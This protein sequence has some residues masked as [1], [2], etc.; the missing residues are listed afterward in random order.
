MTEL[1]ADPLALLRTRTSTKWARYPADVLPM[2]VAEMD[3]PL[4][5]PI[6]AKLVELV[7]RSDV[8]YDSRR[9][10]LGIAFADFA[11]DAWDWTFDPATL[12]WTVNVMH[13]ITEIVRAVI[14]PGDKVLVNTP[15]YPPFFW[16][17][18][19]AGGTR[20]DVPLVRR[21]PMPGGQPDGWRLDL[22][23]IEAAFRDG[24]KAYILC[25]P[26]NPIGFPH[27]REDL[28]RL[29]ELA[30]QYGVLIVSDEI[31]GA[32]THSD[33]EFVPYLAVSDAARATGVCVTSASK[34]FNIPGLTAA[35]WIP[36]SKA[37]ADRLRRLPESLVHRV[38]HFGTHASTVGFA[39]SRQWLA[40]VVETLEARRG[41]L[42]ALLG[43]Q[44]PE[45][46][47]H[48]PT[49]SYLAWIDFRALG[50]G[51]DPARRILKEAKVALNPG[52]GFGAAGKGFARLT[53]ACAPAVLED[54]VTRIAA[55]R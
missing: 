16:A 17:V 23:G 25:H 36:G 49:A 12:K 24:V 6:A 54:A 35:W 21:D 18:D 52:P 53:F 1:A 31:H 10:D 33:A 13:A 9:P 3:Y 39:E 19:E 4:A 28:A 51:D 38:S 37:V 40:D 45:A 7:G 14:E 48:E 2:F 5:P 20:V 26:H 8:G 32:L 50:W 44:L 55:L 22:D 11:R 29:A 27:A 30:E 41:Q 47:L 15:V 46:V 42:R 43:E 34:A